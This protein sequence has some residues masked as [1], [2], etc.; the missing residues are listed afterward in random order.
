MA[1]IRPFQ[2]VRPAKELASSI[3]ALPYDVYNREEARDVVD[4]NPLSFLKIDRA[5]TQFAPDMDMYSQPVYDRARDTLEEMIQD[6]S[7]VRDEAPCYYI[8]TLTMNGLTQTG[9]VGCASIDDYMENRIKKHENTRED[10]ELDRTRHVDTLSAQTGP[11]FLAYHARPEMNTILTDVKMTAPLYDFTSEDSV[12]HQVW[13]I[14]STENITQIAHIF[15]E[16]DNIY[17]ADGHHRAA[18]A[19]K[20]GLKRREEHPDFSGN[21]EFNYFLS[22]LFPAEE[23]HIYDYN[24]VVSDLNGYAFDDFLD[25]LRSGFE[26]S[27]PGSEVCRPSCKGEIGLYGNGSWYRLTAKPFLLSEDPVNRL[28]VSIL[29]NVVLGPL[30]NIRDPKTDKRISF[31]GGIRGL[32]ALAQTVDEGG[33]GA[34]FAMY[35]TSMEELLDVADADRLMPPKSTWFEPKLRSGL[36]IHQFER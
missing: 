30:L 16:I 1:V 20:A 33:D 12:R 35:P 23:L 22:V 6:G 28:D 9:L 29:Q 10:K 8:Y 24:R 3:A 5:E 32:D 21:E 15:E 19:V 27:D 18:S 14:S 13:K 4:K 31:V 25:M 36:F 26:I 2:G 7:F 17:I 34:A 11:I